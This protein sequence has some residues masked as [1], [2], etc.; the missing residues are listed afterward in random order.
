MA[1]PFASILG[2]FSAAAFIADSETVSAT[3]CLIGWP[4]VVGPTT[5][6]G[7]TTVTSFAETP[8]VDY[9]MIGGSSNS[10]DF[11]ENE[12][13]AADGC[14]YLATWNKV[15]Q[16][17][18]QKWVFTDVHTLENIDFEPF[19]SSSDRPHFAVVFNRVGDD[20]IH[21]VI[22]FNKW[23]GSSAELGSIEYTIREEYDDELTIDYN[24]IGLF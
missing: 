5:K 22:T 14:A 11:T 7:D 1:K 9:Y 21:N 17:F 15:S 8:N 23:A 16:K 18:T 2:I 13:C 6:D 10:V 24:N 12:D 19:D 20:E 4:A 3:H